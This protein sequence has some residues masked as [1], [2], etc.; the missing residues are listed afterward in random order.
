MTDLKMKIKTYKSTSNLNVT[1]SVNNQNNEFAKIESIHKTNSIS[2]NKKPSFK[3]F[4]SRSQSNI[5][6]GGCGCGS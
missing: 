1:K 4:V 5:K 6:S 2:N 3:M